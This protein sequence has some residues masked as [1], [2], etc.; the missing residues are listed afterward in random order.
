[1]LHRTRCARVNV[2]LLVILFL[3]VTALGVSLVA[4]RQVRRSILSKMS[5]A[6]GQAAFEKGDWPAASRNLQEYLGRN[7]NDLEILKR[8]AKAR[9]S[10]RPLEAANIVGAISAYRRVLQVAPRDEVAYEQLARLYAGVGNYEDLAYIA[11]MRLEQDPNDRKAPLA[12]GEAL[13]RLNKTAEARQTLEGLIAALEPL[14]DKHDEYVRAC[15]QISAMANLTEAAGAKT[16]REWL[17]KAVAYDPNSAEALA[18]RARFF[19][20]TAGPDSNDAANRTQARRDLEAADKAGTD[21]PLVRCFLGTEWMAWKDLDRAAAELQAAD[22]LPPEK[23]EEYFFDVSSW[24]LT[25]FR[26]AAQLALLRGDAAKGV[27]LA[28]EALTTFTERGHKVA[29][30]P[31]AVS[32]YLAAGDVPKAR[33]CLKDYLESRY[34]DKETAQ[35]R[36]E[37][38]YLQALVARAENN[39]YGV[40]DALQPVVVGDTARTDLWRFLAEAFS[41]TDQSR[42]AVNALTSYLRYRPGDPN[43]TLQLAREYLRLRDWN[44]ALDTARLAEPL[45]PSDYM[46]RLLRIQA[47]VYV[48]AEQDQ[49]VTAATYAKLS[50]ELA[51]LRQTHPE[52]V[53]IR[54]LQAVIA[55]YLKQPDKAEAE[56]KLAIEQCQEPLK[57]E[58]QL[59][60]H[61]YQAKRLEDATRVCQEACTRHPEM[62]EPWL[63]LADLYVT[64]EQYDAAR[65]CLTKGLAAAV[66][67]WEKRSLSIQLALV[68]LTHGDRA[69]G[70]KILS[71]LAAQDPQEIRARSLL[72]SLREMQEETNRARAQ[73]LVDQLKNAEGPNGLWWRLH[74]AALW[75]SS[76]DWRSHQQDITDNLRT[77][78]N[79]DPEWSAPP[80]LLADLYEKLNDAP[81]VEETCKQALQRNPSA[82]EIAD[83]LVSLF[84]RQR[85]FSDA[86][87]VLRQ[88]EANPT[89][90]SGRQAL[91]ALRAGDFERARRELEIRAS[92]NDRDA[93][94]RILLAR[95]LYLQMGD[96]AQA[97]RYIKEAE[98][99]T[100]DSLSL[101]SVKAAI[102]KAEGQGAEAQKTL[103]SYMES[104]KDFAAYYMRASYLAN[105]GQLERAEEDYKKLVTF[106]E[107]AVTG[108][109]LL[110][111]FYANT[112]RL[113]QAVATLEEGLRTHVDDLRLQRGLMQL[114]LLRAQGPDRQRAVEIL[115]TLEKQLPDDP[116]LMRLRAMLLLETAT[117]ESRRTARTMLEEVIKLEPT[118]VDAYVTL[119]NLALQS[120]EYAAARD[121]AVRGLGANS[122]N[123]ALLSARARVELAAK[124]PAMAAELARMV[125]QADP[126]D[127]E[128]INMLVAAGKENNNRSLLNEARTRIDAVVRRAPTNEKLLLTRARILTDL[129][130]PKE[131][132]PELEA[133]CRTKPGSTSVPAFVTLAD[134]YRL[135]GDAERSK[136]WIEQAEHLAPSDQTVVHTRMLW[137]VAQKRWEDLKGISSAYRAASVQN[138][139]LLLRA[140]LTLAACEPAEVKEEG[141]KLLEHAATLWPAAA[142][143]R[144]ELATA[145]YQVGD[146]DRARDIYR[147]LLAQQPKN[148]Q[149]LNDLAWI[150]QEHYQ[151]YEEALKLADQGLEI[152]RDE[153]H[154]LDTR[155]TILSHLPDRL[156]DARKDFER[157]AQLSPAGSP[158]QAKAFLKLGRVCAR[159]GDTTRAK[160]YLQKA[161]DIDRKTKSLTPEERSEIEK[162][163]PPAGQ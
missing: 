58:M 162:T 85:R 1:M 22:A 75:L 109:L 10:I 115:G 91:N 144:V 17:D 163:I 25:R 130:M 6:A 39:W 160:E 11:R 140:A 116:Q 154:L 89:W 92:N 24:K 155:G 107:N 134:L 141:R 36:E 9:L 97:L 67:K 117:P 94:S 69:A 98:A 33:Q 41:R 26:L 71:D 86:E 127:I 79:L 61:Y 13:V 66:N 47:G 84:E 121:Y 119:V 90:R 73:A 18:S 63:S 51:Q 102:L 21:N 59:V 158:A 95:L 60:R 37:V 108:Y 80:L 8:Y 76:S 49:K 129:E 44:R 42:R 14:P 35:S 78:I 83:R 128:A 34:T 23:V 16:A 118:A 110:S 157:L 29:V 120:G 3:V 4:A 105:E 43:M 145:F 74:Q 150:L 114:L 99:I 82:T 126:N 30:L 27:S 28:D 132:A 101:I 131:A 40:I 146:A 113:D 54:I 87:Q 137:L 15:V 64:K 12:L 139:A 31:V 50:D 62:A 93:N 48:A 152:N 123:K 56:L 5:L 161:L 138:P 149:V 112:K 45:N 135:A 7:P 151:S 153:V 19:R 133:Y 104:H 77:C 57:A 125:L 147:E 81:H 52:Q 70:I 53:D 148:G 20:A 142:E 65:E 38:S 103:D 46:V 159:L 2:K 124:N 143:A 111:S 68:E 32:L 100:P 72:L 122:N 136:Q 156:A 88:M 55:D 96:T 106:P